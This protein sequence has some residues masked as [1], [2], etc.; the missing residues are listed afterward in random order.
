MDIYTDFL[1]A[2]LGDGLMVYKDSRDAIIE[3]YGLQR[4]NMGMG[5]GFDWNCPVFDF[6]DLFLDSD[7]PEERP[8]FHEQ[9]EHAEAL[10]REDRMHLP[11]PQMAITLNVKAKIGGYEYILPSVFCAREDDGVIT[12]SLYQNHKNVCDR[13]PVHHEVTWACIAL[14]AQIRGTEYK[15]EDVHVTSISDADKPVVFRR[16]MYDFLCAMGLLNREKIERR[17]GDLPYSA[18]RLQQK[19]RKQIV[20]PMLRPTIITIDAIRRDYAE[21]KAMENLR[22]VSAHA[23]RGHQREYKPGKFTWVK[24]Y[25]KGEHVAKKPRYKVRRN[26][27]SVQS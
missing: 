7:G 4:F 24:P 8:F 18:K 9:F 15:V 26:K 10:I 1:K 14:H 19:H 17:I 13:L 2:R 3:T 12:V 6:G 25:Q 11:F 23:V 20:K 21:R 16:V 22:L 5:Q 27:I